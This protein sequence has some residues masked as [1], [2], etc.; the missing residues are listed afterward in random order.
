MPRPGSEYMGR[1]PHSHTLAPGVR[2]LHDKDC[3]A[4]GLE[5]DVMPGQSVT[6]MEA[7]AK[8][9]LGL[10]QLGNA[11][12]W[13]LGETVDGKVVYRTDID[14]DP[15]QPKLFVTSDEAM[16][17]ADR[18]L[19]N[20]TISYIDPEAENFDESFN[21]H[22]AQ[23][24]CMGCGTKIPQP[25]IF[26]PHVSLCNACYW[27]PKPG[28]TLD[29]GGNEDDLGPD[30]GD[31]NPLPSNRAKLLQPKVNI[32]VNADQ[33]GKALKAMAGAAGAAASQILNA[34]GKPAL[35]K[36]CASC[37]SSKVHRTYCSLCTGCCRDL[38]EQTEDKGRY[39][40]LCD[41][42]RDGGPSPAAPGVSILRVSVDDLPNER[43]F[44]L[45]EDVD[46]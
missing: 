35:T 44:A 3:N 15:I 28:E 27:D 39:V 23:P 21:K 32:N 8:E 25:G 14:P 31:Y 37:G 40:F 29:P 13:V 45:G 20:V 46:D 18:Q 24:T 34:M 1:E 6:E 43:K 5:M 38:S 33:A 7:A 10:Q 22:P 42:Y 26:H 19:N 2:I 4:I 41:Y 36:K 12:G 11:Q 16:Y 30:P 17:L 9:K